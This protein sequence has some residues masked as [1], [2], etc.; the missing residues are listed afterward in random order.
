[1]EKTKHNFIYFPMLLSVKT[2][3]GKAGGSKAP[4]ASPVWLLDHYL[5]WEINEAIAEKMGKILSHLPL[6]KPVV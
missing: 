6:P 1:M 2:A 3:K 5:E 4:M